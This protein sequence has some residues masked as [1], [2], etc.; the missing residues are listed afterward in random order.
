MSGRPLPSRRLLAVGAT[1]V[2]AGSGAGAAA[3]AVASGGTPRVAHPR[4]A[5]MSA[6][7][8]APAGAP[9]HWLPK[10]P[11]VMQH[12]LPYDEQRLYATLGVDRGTVARWLRVHGHTLAELAAAHGHADRAALVDT[13]LAP[14]RDSVDAAT[15]A[16]LRRRADDTLTQSHLAQHVFSHLFHDPAIPAGAET[17]FGV[18]TPELRR[19]R[20][21]GLTPAQIGARGGRTREQV[22][23]D[24]MRVLAESQR[25]G[26]AQGATTAAQSAAFLTVQRRAVPRWLDRAQHV[27]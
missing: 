1:C 24:L 14:R 21:E 23:G 19:L 17:I 22:A 13:L 27:R 16:V 4:A 7:S 9:A 20:R 15:F 11:W 26:R 10:D 2:L 25:V 18:S 8:H 3:V 12:W 5:V 6:D